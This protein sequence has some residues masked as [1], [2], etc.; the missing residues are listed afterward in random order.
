M[1]LGGQDFFIG[2]LKQIFS[3]HKKI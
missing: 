3:G 1:F 2:Y